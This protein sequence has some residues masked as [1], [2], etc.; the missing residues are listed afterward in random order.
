MLQVQ[1]LHEA[2]VLQRLHLLL[3]ECV[4]ELRVL[5]RSGLHEI[6]DLKGSIAVLIFSHA[7]DV[8]RE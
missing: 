7:L 3:E 5:G 6:L 4:I 2:K 8:V 1:E